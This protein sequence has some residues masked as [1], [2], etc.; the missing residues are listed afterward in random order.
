MRLYMGFPTI[1]ELFL[2]VWGP[3]WAQAN[4]H[5]VLT[6]SSRT[7]AWRGMRGKP[8]T[9]ELSVSMTYWGFVGNKGIYYTIKYIE[10]AI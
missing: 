2:G 3:H 5:I 1:R 8:I 7:P 9:N 10:G 6:L 4:Y